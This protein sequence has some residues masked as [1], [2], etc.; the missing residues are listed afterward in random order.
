MTK[1]IKEMIKDIKEEGK[2]QSI[3]YELRQKLVEL[4]K[5]HIEGKLK[6]TSKLR[7]IRKDI[8]RVLTKINQ[9][10]R[11]NAKKNA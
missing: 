1:N 6:D 3:L 11:K 4:K 8:A 2:L 5:Q 10:K 7:K 9:L